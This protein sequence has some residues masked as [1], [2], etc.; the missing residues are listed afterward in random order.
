MGRVRR[1]REAHGG[2]DHHGQSVRTPMAQTRRMEK[3]A[4]WGVAN[5]SAE[6]FALPL[7]GFRPTIV[8]PRGHDGHD[9][10]HAFRRSGTESPDLQPDEIKQELEPEIKHATPGVA[11]L[12][13]ADR[14]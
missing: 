14:L 7:R 5:K 1:A 6:V 9:L 12:F 4:Q 11:N 10:P 13:G 3:A 2:A 8:K